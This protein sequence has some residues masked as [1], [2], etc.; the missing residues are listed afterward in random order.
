MLPQKSDGKA[1]PEP[2]PPDQKLLLQ[3]VGDQVKVSFGN[4]PAIQGAYRIDPTRTP[5]ALD[6]SD[7]FVQIKLHAI[8]RRDGD[9]LFICTGG[10]RPTDFTTKPGDGRTLFIFARGSGMEKPTER[11]WAQVFNGKDFDGWGA[12]PKTWEVLKNETLAFKGPKAAPLRT[13]KTYTDFCVR[14][15]YQWL[16]QFPKTH[17]PFL[18]VDLR[19][20]D[21][22]AALDPEMTSPFV[23]LLPQ[24]MA[25][26]DKLMGGNKILPGGTVIV[27]MKDFR[28]N[29]LSNPQA[30]QFQDKAF[31]PT[32][33]NRVEIRCL[34]ASLEVMSNGVSMAKMPI[35]KAFAGAIVLE[36]VNAGMIFRN[37]EMKELP[38]PL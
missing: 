33:W 36:P 4:E 16:K 20:P 10:Q 18:N 7:V 29:T 11:G 12:D 6:F 32:G 22:K 2:L 35:R 17:A 26:P 30:Q 13:K 15:D 8:Y 19:V 25:V 21:P 9:K 23:Q 14:F 34:G 27:G 28:G 5:A 37:I 3:F 24:G 38:P 1:S 31:Q